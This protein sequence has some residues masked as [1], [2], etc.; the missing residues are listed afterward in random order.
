M[1]L[2]NRQTCVQTKQKR[3][4]GSAEAWALDIEAQFRSESVLSVQKRREMAHLGSLVKYVR[5]ARSFSRQNVADK[6]KKGRISL[7]NKLGASKKTIDT[8]ASDFMSDTYSAPEKKPFFKKD[9]N[10]RARYLLGRVF[11]CPSPRYLSCTNDPLKFNHHRVHPR[12][13]EARV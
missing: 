6:M 13:V 9:R 8:Y 12:H 4:H 3:S 7:K 11:A 1:R 5:T 2:A 10:E